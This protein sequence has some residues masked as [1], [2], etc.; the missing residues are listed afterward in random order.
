[1]ALIKGAQAANQ[2][3]LPLRRHAAWPDARVAG[4]RWAVIKIAVCML[5]RKKA[6]RVKRAWFYLGLG[7]IERTDNIMPQSKNW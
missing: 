6:R 1:M 5:E 7:R 3:R 2:A 4:I